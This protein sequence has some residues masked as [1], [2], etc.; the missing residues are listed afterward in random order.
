MISRRQTR[1]SDRGSVD[2]AVTLAAL[3]LTE[4]LGYRVAACSREFYPDAQSQCGGVPVDSLDERHRTKDALDTG[5]FV[6]LVHVSSTNASGP[7]RSS[8]SMCT[9]GKYVYERFPVRVRVPI[10]ARL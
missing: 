4:D 2:L 8:R 9:G 1:L 3:V 6:Y 5:L 10:V 7:H